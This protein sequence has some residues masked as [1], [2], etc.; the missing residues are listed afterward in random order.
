MYTH[1][2]FLLSVKFAA[3]II[4]VSSPCPDVGPELSLSLE[5]LSCPKELNRLRKIQHA[6]GT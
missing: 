2:L 3:V 5:Q 1:L 4:T 6:C